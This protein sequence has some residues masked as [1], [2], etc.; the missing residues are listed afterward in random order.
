MKKTKKIIAVVAAASTLLANCITA[1]ANSIVSGNR[2]ID[3]FS[4]YVTAGKE[5]KFVQGGS[6]GNTLEFSYAS[7]ASCKITCKKN[8]AVGLS[9]GTDSFHG[10]RT[11]VIRG[12]GEYN[13]A[14][15]SN[16]NAIVDFQLKQATADQKYYITFTARQYGPTANDYATINITDWNS[17]ARIH[18]NTSNSMWTITDLGYANKDG[19]GGTGDSQWYQYDAVVTSAATEPIVRFVT[20][21]YGKIFLDDVCVKDSNGNIIFSEDFEGDTVEKEWIYKPVN[22]SKPASFAVKEQKNNASNHVLKITGYDAGLGQYFINL[23]HVQ[24]NIYNLSYEVISAGDR[25]ASFGFIDGDVY[26]SYQIPTVGVVNKTINSGGNTMLRINAQGWANLEIDNI[27]IKDKNGN[28][29]YEE[30]FDGN[31]RPIAYTDGWT[32]EGYSGS[33]FKVVEASGNHKLQASSDGTNNVGRY[34]IAL[35]EKAVDNEYHISYDWEKIGSGSGTDA[36]IDLAGNNVYG[37]GQVSKLNTEFVTTSSSDYLYISVVGWAGVYIDNIVVKDKNGNVLFTEDFENF[38]DRYTY[39]VEETKLQGL[40]ANGG[41][42]VI[43]LSWRNPKRDDI[44]SIQIFENGVET[45]SSQLADYYLDSNNVNVIEISDNLTGVGTVHD[46][47]VQMTLTSGQVYHNYI[48][49]KEGEKFLGA[50]LTKDGKPLQG[51][52]VTTVDGDVPALGSV[53]YDTINKKVGNASLHINPNIT[54]TSGDQENDNDKTH[55][56]ADLNDGARFRLDTAVY[57]IEEGETYQLTWKQKGN[58]A[59]HYY[60]YLVGTE[61][62]S[63]G[64]FTAQTGYVDN[65]PWQNKSLTFTAGSLSTTSAPTLRFEF[66]NGCDDFWLDDMKL[67]KVGTNENLLPNGSFEYGIDKLT[68]TG[69]TVTWE[70]QD[71][72]DAVN[73]YR[74]FGD[75]LIKVDSLAAGTENY[76]IPAF[77]GTKETLVFR[78]VKKSGATEFLSEKYSVENSQSSYIYDAKLEV[79]NQTADDF[80]VLGIP[81]TLTGNILLKA[82][83]KIDN[84]TDNNIV[85]ADLYTMIYKDGALFKI[86]KQTATAEKSVNANY[87]SIISVPSLTDGEYTAKVAVWKVGEITPIK[88]IKQLDE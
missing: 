63:I 34:K 50:D 16:G 5:N 22:G 40:S 15:S 41:D 82:T 31:R 6:S 10:S 80:V 4:T 54:Y 28:V 70:L 69:N 23:P 85:G 56:M 62:T 38:E 29:I 73:V 58:H 51:W 11:L 9:D 37:N 19:N 76:T 26:G 13:D 18:E 2:Y 67:V 84:A 42:D 14:K 43:Y 78:T 49:G 53:Y 36:S 35:P 87:S 86:D 39:Y 64:S 72:T 74:V 27:M 65:A 75:T 57:G 1:N 46:Y 81:E 47:D 33:T 30:D 88:N 21:S 60:V 17:K 79:V 20:Y 12:E 77:D 71:T 68:K 59:P 8:A 44:A 7:G 61:A 52:R 66:S 3:P 32:R 45:D 48:S 24:D 55:V 25:T 83:L